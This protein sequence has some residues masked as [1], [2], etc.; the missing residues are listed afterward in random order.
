MKKSASISMIAGLA[1]SSC[2]EGWKDHRPLG[3]R[4]QTLLHASSAQRREMRVIR[5]ENVERFGGK[6]FHFN[7]IEG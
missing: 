4:D 1:T 6:G 7:R 5:S 3:W 2:I